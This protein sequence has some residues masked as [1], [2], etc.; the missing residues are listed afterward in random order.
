M[1]YSSV[2][3]HRSMAFD[4]Q[5]NGLYERAI[6]AR[7][8]PGQ[9]VMDLGAGVGLHGLMAAAAGASRVYLVEPQP[10]VNLAAQ[11]ARAAGLDAATTV[12]IQERI[13]DAQ[14]PEPVD[15]IISVFTGNLLFT[16][17]LLPSLFHARDRYL[18][19][20]GQ[21]LPDRAQLWLA[22]LSAP[23]LHA[24]H[25]A[26]WSQPVQGFDYSAG[27]GFAANELLGLRRE[28][29]VG[30]QRL[31]DGAVLADLDFNVARDAHCAG[32]ASCRVEVSG[33]CHGLLGW[34]RV[35]LLDDEWLSTAPD[36]PDVHW[37]PA[38]LP[39]DPPLPL[40]AGEDLALTLHRPERGDWTWTVAARAGNRR[41]STF[42]ARTEAPRDLARVAPASTVALSERGQRAL[43]ALE[44][45]RAGHSIAQTAQALSGT[46]DIGIDRL[47]SEVQALA[48]RYGTSR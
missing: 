27:R 23:K 8:T 15:L 25:I 7:V 35:H 16:E 21:L 46:S 42:L 10:V 26:R 11:A 29:L 22:P 24:D 6:R 39:V 9:V 3:M 2:G 20:G 45:L 40:E 30:S 33:L 31:A 38:F 32:R 14:L 37:S 13:E 47:V 4:A 18:K 34:I 43:D 17:D 5:R 28:E 1:S 44:L 12:V 36:A 48:L 41:H 19:P